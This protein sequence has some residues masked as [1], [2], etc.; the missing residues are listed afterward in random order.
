MLSLKIAMLKE[1]V[2]EQED[3]LQVEEVGFF[4]AIVTPISVFMGMSAAIPVISMSFP[5]DS[6]VNFPESFQSFIS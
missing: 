4:M 2:I 6:H 5:I 3:E 1:P